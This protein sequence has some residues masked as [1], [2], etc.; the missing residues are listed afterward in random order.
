[1]RLPMPQNGNNPVVKW[2]REDDGQGFQRG[3]V[4]PLP[5]RESNGRSEGLDD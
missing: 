4:P 5:T 3:L 2:K 1:M